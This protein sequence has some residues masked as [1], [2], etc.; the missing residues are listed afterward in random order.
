MMHQTGTPH[1]TASGIVLSPLVSVQ[2]IMTVQLIPNDGVYGKRGHGSLVGCFVDKVI[3]V[4]TLQ[5]PVQ[6]VARTSKREGD[7]PV[8]VSARTC[9]SSSSPED[10]T[11]LVYDV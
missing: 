7:H 5:L 8:G 10:Y 6:P 4:L 2:G 3:D 11:H 9:L 1:N